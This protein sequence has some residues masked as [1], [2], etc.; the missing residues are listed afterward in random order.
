MPRWYSTAIQSERTAAARL[1]LPRQLDRPA[2]QQQ[3]L[4]QGGFAGVRVRMIA[5]VR[6]RIIS[7]VRVRITLP[8]E[9]FFEV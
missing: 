6:R 4:G 1:D 8:G 5:N 3:F 2:K 7:S 9:L